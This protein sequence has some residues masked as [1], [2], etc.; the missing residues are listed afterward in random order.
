MCTLTASCDNTHVGQTQR[1]LVSRI[2]T[3]NQ[4]YMPT[5]IVHR[6][7]WLF[8]WTGNLGPRWRSWMPE[9]DCECSRIAQWINQFYFGRCGKMRGST[10]RLRGLAKWPRGQRVI[11]TITP[12]LLSSLV[13]TRCSFSLCDSRHGE[14]FCNRGL[15]QSPFTV[16]CSLFCLRLRLVYINCSSRFIPY[17]LRMNTLIS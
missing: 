4:K 12:R 16:F 10:K 6:R 15:L 7:C 14:F 13:P 11:Q 9:D 1:K 8:Q 2:R 3:Q 5:P 17:Y